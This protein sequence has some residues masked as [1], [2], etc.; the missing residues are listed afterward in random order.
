MTARL[1]L[2]ATC[3]FWA[4]TAASGDIA[5]ED[6]VWNGSSIAESL[7]GVPGDADEGFNVF[8]SRSIGNCVACHEIMSMP[9]IDWPGDV[10]P[11]LDGAAERWTEA[12]LRGLVVD[13]KRTYEGSMMISFY[14]RSG[15]IRPGE[16][17]T[18]RAPEGGESGLSTLLTAQQVE[19][20]VAFLQTLTWDD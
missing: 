10:G 8:S 2:G 12:E 3:A 13:A 7:T 1:L 11:P 6:I 15:Y 14:K 16:A 20:V 19:D 5:P 9:H 18:G 4:A 17:Y